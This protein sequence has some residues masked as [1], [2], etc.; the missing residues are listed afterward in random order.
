MVGQ[1]IKTVLDQDTRSNYLNLN[2]LNDMRRE[3]SFQKTNKKLSFQINNTKK[4]RHPALYLDT[5][6]MIDIHKNRNIS[7]TMLIKMIDD[8]EWICFTSA[9]AFMEMIDIE[10]DDEFVRLSRGKGTDYSK[11]CRERYNR[12]MPLSNLQDAETKFKNFFEKYPFIHP[13]AMNNKGWDLALHITSSSS[14]F[15]PDAIHLATAWIS[16]C[17]L[18]ITN[19]THFAKESTELLKQE[20]V[21]NRFA[22]CKAK[23]AVKKMNSMG[24]KVEMQS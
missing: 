18:L 20:D 3:I 15:A 19:D 7:S 6:V 12:T 21:S 14:I 8:K 2:F 10:Q 11:I 13:V 16:D 23:D 9:F 22:V 1:T 5:N 17:D 24:F 4:N